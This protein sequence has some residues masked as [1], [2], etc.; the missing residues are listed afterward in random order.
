MLSVVNPEIVT[1]VLSPNL[2]ILVVGAGRFEQYL[3]S[4]IDA[5]FVANVLWME[6]SMLKWWRRWRAERLM[7]TTAA[8]EN[9]PFSS[10]EMRTLIQRGHRDDFKRLAAGLSKQNGTRGPREPDH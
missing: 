6:Q 3:S 4:I 7:R 5:L 1:A 2:I 8:D 9:L 10:E